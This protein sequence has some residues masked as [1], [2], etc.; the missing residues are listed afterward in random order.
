MIKPI[1][2]RVVLKELEAAETTGSGLV[3]AGQKEDHQMAEVIAVSDKVKNLEVG[4]R[5]QVRR[6]ERQ[7]F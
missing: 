4:Q 6:P 3:L 1:G 5:D 7:A 2:K